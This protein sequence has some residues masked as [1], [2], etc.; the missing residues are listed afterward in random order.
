V[1]LTV[2]GGGRISASDAVALAQRIVRAHGGEL[3]IREHEL[4]VQLRE[5]TATA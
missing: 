2:R 1:Q 4:V 5:Y 3:E